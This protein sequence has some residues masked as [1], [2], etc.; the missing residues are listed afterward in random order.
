MMKCISLAH[1]RIL[2]SRKEW[3]ISWPM[4]EN[5]LPCWGLWST[6]ICPCQCPRQDAQA[7]ANTHPLSL[8]FFLLHPLLSHHYIPGFGGLGAVWLR[9]HWSLWRVDTKHGSPFL[10]FHQGIYSVLSSRALCPPDPRSSFSSYLKC[11]H[12]QKCQVWFSQRSLFSFNC[13]I[14]TLYIF[15]LYLPCV[16]YCKLNRQISWLL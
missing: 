15:I 16:I 3:A 10:L 12:P 5:T 6:L 7:K 4:T 2:L 1:L 13:D 9:K 11:H 14:L 8:M